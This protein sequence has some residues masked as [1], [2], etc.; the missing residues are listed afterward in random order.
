MWQ[1][2]SF[3]KKVAVG[4]GH[5]VVM[6]EAKGWMGYSEGGYGRWKFGFDHGRRL[7]SVVVY[8]IH[9]RRRSKKSVQF[10]DDGICI[11]S[12]GGNAA[13]VRLCG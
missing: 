13:I 9:R 6:G 3:A 10:A 8:R 7:C 5:V 4:G 12:G 1:F 11:H 2:F